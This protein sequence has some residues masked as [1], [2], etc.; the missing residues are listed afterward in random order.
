MSDS[1]FFGSDHQ[2]IK[3][4]IMGDSEAAKM[5]DPRSCPTTDVLNCIQFLSAVSH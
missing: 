5:V 3:F 2:G 1:S 4:A